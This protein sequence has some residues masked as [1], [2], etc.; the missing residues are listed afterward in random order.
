MDE[1]GIHGGSQICVVAG[2]VAPLATCT[3]LEREWKNLLHRRS[4]QHFHAKEFSNCSDAFYGWDHSR[5]NRFINDAYSVINSAMDDN[6]CAVIGAAVPTIDFYALSTDE[7]RWLTGGALRINGKW[8][9]SGSPRKPYFLPFQQCVVDSV[10]TI[11]NPIHFVFDQQTDYEIH[12][13]KLF[14][15]L[16]E[17]RSDLVDAFGDIVYTSKHRALP[18]QIADFIAYESYQFL[19]GKRAKSMATDRTMASSLPIFQ[20][21]NLLTIISRKDLARMLFEQPIMPGK[22]FIWPERKPKKKA[23]PMGS[24]VVKFAKG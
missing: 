13:N 20:R 23:I 12:A 6:G 17:Q 16:R 11:K 10:E 3:L 5:K 8:I 2:F 19:I 21:H 18:L 14:R 9:D 4:V 24:K 15:I 1:S 7:R 22:R